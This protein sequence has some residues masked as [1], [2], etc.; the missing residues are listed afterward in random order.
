MK[1]L[2]I[3]AVALSVSSSSIAFGHEYIHYVPKVK[4]SPPVQIQGGTNWA[5][6]IVG[7]LVACPA[8]GLLGYGAYIANTQHRQLTCREAH[9]V[10][11][12]CMIPVV[13]AYLVNAGFSAHPEWEAECTAKH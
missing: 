11:W 1:R 4:P 3:L 12:G 6:W 10:V 2:M 7:G 8:V 5:P 13:G 9:M